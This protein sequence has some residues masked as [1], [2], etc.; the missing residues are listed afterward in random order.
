M[1]LSITKGQFTE[2]ELKTAIIYLFEAQ[3]CT[4]FHGDSIHRRFEDILF[5]NDLRAF[6]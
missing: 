6:L 4:S 3:G 2:S 1:G 5:E